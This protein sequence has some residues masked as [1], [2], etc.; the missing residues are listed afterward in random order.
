MPALLHDPLDR[1]VV[2]AGRPAGVA[3]AVE[4]PGEVERAHVGVLVQ[5]LRQCLPPNA[6]V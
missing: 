1:H 5:E 2:H 6:L 4:V 3:T